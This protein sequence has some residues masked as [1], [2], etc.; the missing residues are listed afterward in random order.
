MIV[1]GMIGSLECAQNH[2]GVVLGQT[3]EQRNPKRKMVASAKEKMQLKSLV[4]PIAALVSDRLAHRFKVKY[5]ML[6]IFTMRT[7]SYI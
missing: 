7:I 4:I 5:D 2:A 6:L 1:N 3:L